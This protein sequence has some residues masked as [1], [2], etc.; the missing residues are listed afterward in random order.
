V[1]QFVQTFSEDAPTPPIPGDNWLDARDASPRKL[2]EFF[3]RVSIRVRNSPAF[4]YAA[5]LEKHFHEEA[6]AKEPYPPNF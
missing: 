1:Y 2:G 3:G 4:D 6:D 5:A